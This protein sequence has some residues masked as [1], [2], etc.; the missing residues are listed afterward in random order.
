MKICL[1]GVTEPS[2]NTPSWKL[3]CEGPQP[4][5]GSR[6]F[7]MN[8]SVET[9]PYQALK[10]LVSEYVPIDRD[11]LHIFLGLLL[12]IVAVSANRH[13]KRSSTFLL[14]F[15]IACAIGAAMELADMFDDVNSLGQ[16]RWRESILDFL[17]TI[18]FPGLALFFDR[19]VRCR[20][21]RELR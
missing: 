15:M 6:F 20:R 1:S 13:R 9:S 10:L 12:V 7:F 5:G 19:I 8:N 16:W 4:K 3:P 17:A 21:R 11:Y 2:V 18:L 14:T